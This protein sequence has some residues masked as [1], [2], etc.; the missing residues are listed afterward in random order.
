MTLRKS[1]IL[2][3]STLFVVMLVGSYFATQ[4]FLLGSFTKLEYQNK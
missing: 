3:I 4:H 2:A 1:T